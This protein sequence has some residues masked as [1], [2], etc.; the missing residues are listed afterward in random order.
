MRD[1]KVLQ[2]FFNY[3]CYFLALRPKCTLEQ[4]AL[5]SAKCAEGRT[6]PGNYCYVRSQFEKENSQSNM[7][8][9]KAGT[10]SDFYLKIIDFNYSPILPSIKKKTFI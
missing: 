3:Y 10:R 6:A 2:S 1:L 8:V 4:F 9:V 7:V 5:A